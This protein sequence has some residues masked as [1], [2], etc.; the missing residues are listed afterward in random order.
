MREITEILVS[1]ITNRGAK[2]RINART[3]M[4]FFNA[5]GRAIYIPD[6]QRPYSWEDNQRNKLFSDLEKACDDNERWFLGPIYTTVVDPESNSVDILDGQQRMTTITIILRETLAFRARISSNEVWTNDEFKRKWSMLETRC[7]S[8]IG[9]LG[10]SSLGKPKFYTDLSVRD[11]FSNWIT[12]A[13]GLED[14]VGYT[15]A[16]FIPAQH[17][18]LTSKR[19]VGAIKNVSNWMDGVVKI[20]PN[21]EDILEGYNNLYD[22]INHLLD[23]L[24]LIEIP[25]NSDDDIL[26]V[27]EAMNNRGLGLSLSDK[28]RFKTISKTESGREREIISKTWGKIYQACEHLVSNGLFGGGVDEFLEVYLVMKGAQTDKSKDITSAE[29]REA[30]IDSLIHESSP[31]EVMDEVLKVT[32]FYQEFVLDGAKKAIE[33]LKNFQRQGQVTGWSPVKFDS[34]SALANLS[35][36]MIKMSKNF[37]I[38]MHEFGS[39]YDLI[40]SSF[41]TASDTWA[42]IRILFQEVVI[43]NSTSNTVREKMRECV[44]LNQS[45]NL[46]Q[47]VKFGEDNKGWNYRNKWNLFMQNNDSESFASLLLFQWFDDKAMLLEMNERSVQGL[48]NHLEHVCPKKWMSHWKDAN[49]DSEIKELQNNEGEWWEKALCEDE[50]APT[51]TG[52]YKSTLIECI[53]NKAILRASS[54]IKGSNKNW[55]DKK[56]LFQSENVNLYPNWREVAENR[57]SKVTDAEDR[58]QQDTY[59]GEFNIWDSRII[60]QNARIFM[61]KIEHNWTN[62]WDD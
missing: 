36:G 27:F 5:E 29:Q 23:G 47:Q 22:Y 48:D 46:T 14:E 53:G 16:S 7:S 10:S 18:Q 17:W 54:N 56:S 4:D 60:V 6:Y 39:N 42:G 49:W 61:E 58:S 3:V 2:P 38:L 21:Q 26:K 30:L 62:A 8:A 13:L 51:I 44:K 33:H 35:R 12:A 32:A 43:F 57:I 41:I 28:M 52:K 24:W 31:Q 19:I 37:R 59:W 1:T 40:S 25:F 45:G 11:E 20:K 55:S 9:N 15:N 50:I 34:L